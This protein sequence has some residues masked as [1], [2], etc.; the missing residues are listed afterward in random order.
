MYCVTGSDF[1]SGLIILVLKQVS[2]GLLQWLANTRA[3]TGPC[4]P[5][6]AVPTWRREN[7]DSG[8]YTE[9]SKQQTPD[10]STWESCCLSRGLQGLDTSALERSPTMTCYTW[11]LLLALASVRELVECDYSSLMLVKFSTLSSPSPILTD[12]RYILVFF[13]NWEI[14]PLK[15]FVEISTFQ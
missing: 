5:S 10:C 1:N 8:S 9:L 4:S 14:F 13:L 12:R 6:G 2:R 11:L 7:K 3:T 15:S